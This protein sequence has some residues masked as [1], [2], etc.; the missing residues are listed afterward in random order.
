MQGLQLFYARTLPEKVYIQFDKP[1]YATGET[2]WFKAYAV[3]ADSHRA[4][5]LSKVLY[6]DMVSEKKQIVFRRT[7]R[8]QNGLATGDFALP[9]TLQPGHYLVR[10]YTNWMRN[11]GEDFFYS[12]QLAIWGAAAP[13][14]DEGPA[15]RPQKSKGSSKAVAADVDVQFFPEGGNLVDELESEVGFKVVD[16]T[17]RG[18]SS[19]GKVMTADGTVVTTFTSRHAGM[20]SFRLIPQSGQRYE[21]EVTLP[22]GRRA[23]YPLPRSQPSGWLLRV[24]ETQEYYM[25]II[26]RR[27]SAAEPS[28]STA[29]L[30]AHVRGAVVYT[31]QTP[32]N[33]NEAF[34]TRIPKSKFPAGIAHFTLFDA[35]NEPQ[36][37]RLV[38][39]PETEPVRVRIAT[40]KQAYGP[41]EP[42][43]LRIETSGAGGQPVSANVSVA[44]A[45]L[46]GQPGEGATIT[47]HLL[48]TSD[49]GGYVEDA[50]YYLQDQQP[51]TR[52]A[53]NDLLLTQ[54]WRRFVWK[55]Q[56]AGTLPPAEFALE[57]GLTL[58]GQV[59]TA[60]RK[61]APATRL[62]YLQ[63][64]P[65]KAFYTAE[66]DKEGLFLFE[67]LKGTDTAKIALQARTPENKRNLFIR[68]TPP[69]TTAGVILAPL[70][71]MPS[72][73]VSDYIRLSQRQ[74]VAESQLHPN[75]VKTIALGNIRVKAKK[76]GSTPSPLNSLP[77]P[78][79][80]ANVKEFRVADMP[81]SNRALLTVEEFL[82]GRVILRPNQAP[83]LYL[84]DGIPT[85]GANKTSMSEVESIDVLSGNN[86]AIFGSIGAGGVISIFSRNALT[87]R[88][89]ESYKTKEGDKG[90]LTISFP[91]YY[92]GREFYT[93]RFADAKTK[94][95]PD[96][97]HTTLSWNPTVQ[98]DAT[99]QATLSF[100]TSD[101]PGEYRVTVEGMTAGGQPV[102]GVG[103]IT[104]TR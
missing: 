18:V 68:L 66:T 16:E 34:I 92:K 62:T 84:L 64:Q 47:S 72:A 40:D 81:E 37:E 97:R 101:A 45:A 71:A 58:G 90:M 25:A 46:Q 21:A 74:Q 7:L 53:L 44:V 96:P 24:T 57:Q 102:Q 73:T 4:D 11:A 32:V 69:P 88:Y 82:Q 87:H 41:R 104:C 26:R 19:Q 49:L 78:Y 6:V 98:T 103:Q 38:F 52:Q 29:V 54:G 95:Q 31:G 35:R 33:G 63:A 12:H 67:G 50:A 75:A 77:R 3:M 60:A 80:L 14:S 15:T 8:L 17:G 23:T 94:N 86:V 1:F 70:P 5:T 79:S 48:L 89:S 2:V 20:G 9:D 10:A 22:D 100:Y 99:G 93:P 65:D 43:K 59:L 30:L 91:G 42:V 55:K 27:A 28:Q 61:P 36:C 39:T 51:A 13:S 83:P 85:S 56:L 76:S